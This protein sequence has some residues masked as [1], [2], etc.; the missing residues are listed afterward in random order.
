LVIDNGIS[1]DL[2]H[3]M[4][5]ESK[6]LI[7][8]VE[9]RRTVQSISNEDA[10]EWVS[11][12]ETEHR[13]FASLC[14]ELMCSRIEKCL[15]DALWASSVD[16]YPEE[17]LKHTLFPND[18]INYRPSYWSSTGKSNPATSESLIYRLTSR[19]CLVS[20]VYVHPFEA[21]FQSG[22]PLYSSERVRF[23]LGYWKDPESYGDD[24]ESPSSF[25]EE[26]FVWTYSSP[27][28]QMA[29]VNRLQKF[30]LPKPVFCIGGILKVELI[31]RVQ[32]QQMDG[33]YYICVTHVQVVGTRI[34]PHF[35]VEAADGNGKFT[36]KY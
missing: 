34:S 13:A 4:F 36:L 14:R 11:S 19:L 32:T 12:P 10:V 5:P 35:D 1:K 6:S 2:C 15:A 24:D 25:T 31:G 28:F 30:E 26:S 17:G 20:E 9:P 23:H 3:R 7:R 27:E 21:Y 18:K 33:L 8:V 16:N 29:R 22:A